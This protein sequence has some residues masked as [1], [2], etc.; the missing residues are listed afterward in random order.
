MPHR[1]DEIYKA[2]SDG[3]RRRILAAVCREP[4]VAGDL[5]RLVE[6]AP[7]AVSFHLKWLRSAGLVSVRRRG[8]YLHYAADPSG[9]A[10]LREHVAEL[11]LPTEG[12]LRIHNAKGP[13]ALPGGDVY[14]MAARKPR[15]PRRQAV[16]VAHGEQDASDVSG[17]AIETLTAVASQDE[18]LPTELL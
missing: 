4:M 9:V 3:H 18:T 17:G 8:K 7:N 13:E 15:R 2:L 14:P 1:F 12:L 11:F 16:P 6:L 10:S 5:G